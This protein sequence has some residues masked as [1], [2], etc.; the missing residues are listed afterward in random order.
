MKKNCGKALYTKNSGK[1]LL[2]IFLNSTKHAVV[3]GTTIM[4]GSIVITS[5]EDDDF[6]KAIL[7]TERQKILL[8]IYEYKTLGYC[9]HFH[10]WEIQKS[11]RKRILLCN[12]IITRQLLYPQVASVDTYFVT[13]KFAA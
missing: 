1:V 12:N 4:P 9:Q 8:C 7:V 13:L 5:P 10:S 3:N 11:S 2:F 6:L